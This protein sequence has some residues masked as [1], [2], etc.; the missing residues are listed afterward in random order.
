[1]S[2]L[3]KHII[4]IALLLGLIM[5]IFS[6]GQN[7]F[8]YTFDN[9]KIH[10]TPISGKYIVEFPNGLNQSTQNG[11]I[12]G[13]NAF[14]GQKISDKVYLVVDT[15]NLNNYSTNYNIFPTY[16]T[17]GDG[18]ELYI[19]SH[20]LLKFKESTTTSAKQTLIANHNLQL[21]KS[22][23]PYEMYSCVDPL[24][25]SQSIYE[26]GL[27]EYCHPDFICPNVKPNAIPN[28]EY[29]A[30]QWYLH[31][32]GQGT[33]DGK[34]TTNDADIDAPEAW[35][36][37]LGNS[38]I[39]VAVIDE[40]VTSNHPDLPN[41]R[42][43]RLNGSNFASP[44]DGTNNANDPSPVN[45]LTSGNNH[46][47][48]CA[49]VIGASHNNNIGISGIAPNCKILPVKIPFGSIPSSVYVD[50]I[51]FAYQNADIL[52]NSWGYGSSNPNLIPAI[53]TAIEDAIDD[54]KIVVFAAGNT[55]DHNANYGGFVS[56]PGNADIDNLITVGASD[57]ND[58]QANYSPTDEEFEIVAP[59][60]SAY[61]SQIAGEAFNV[62]TI[63]IPGDYGYNKWRDSWSN[64]LPNVG[65]FL[66]STGSNAYAY[67]GRFG[68]TSAACPQVA[69]V[70][71]L[72]LSENPCLSPSQIKDLLQ[73][74][75]DKVGSYNYNWNSDIPGHSKEL[76]FGRL[77]AY[78]AVKAAQDMNSSTLDLYMRDRHDDLG[79]DAGYTW[80]WDFDDSPDI[81]VR[82]QNDGLTNQTHE[83]PEYQAS[84]PVYVYVRVGNKSCVPS[85]GNEKLA[86]YWTKASS[87]SSW[88]Q[89]WDGT[90]PTVGNIINDLTI[91]V[92]QPGE[93]TIL[94]FTWN[95]AP[96]TGIGTTWNNCLLA[97]IENSTVDAITVHPNDLGQDVYQN[98]N[99]SLRNCVVTNYINGI[100]P[101]I[102]VDRERFFYIGN[103]HDLAQNYDIIFRNS[104]NE[105][106]PITDVAEVNVQLDQQGWNLLV[107][108]LSD[109]QDIRIKDNN[110]FTIV[111]NNP[112]SLSNINFPANTR[113]PVKIVYNFLTDEVEN[114]NTYEYH[115]IQK[116]TI[117]HNEL[118]DHWT[119]G[120]HFI[121]NKGARNL[122]DADAGDDEEIDKGESITITAEQI[123]EAA[124]YNWYDSEGNLIFTGTSL[125][126]SPEVTEKYKL[127]VV[128]DADGFK[129][130]DEV[131]VKV[132][133]YK[134]E[135]LSPN[136]ANTNVTIEY[137][138]EGANSAYLMIV[139]ASNFTPSNNYI[140]NSSQTETNIDVTNYQTGIYT[141][142]LVVDGQIVDAMALMIQ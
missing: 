123:N 24:S 45:S 18:E 29:F 73:K 1:M 44:Y 125:S 101:P 66:P 120:V 32:T 17:Q 21:I 70:S 112:V 72:M 58:N 99:V 127:E 61:N 82:N 26:S 57:R 71:A 115:V 16:L 85:S 65:E 50:A 119:G 28:D 69:G 52:S 56:F 35:D 95:I 36:L 23:S 42:Q 114:L 12:P 110:T 30:Q 98:N 128:A 68:G 89:N 74:S 124:K 10:L 55:A 137:D 11:M 133:R 111:G 117:T 141:V 129:D 90:D 93:S 37:S 7:N 48:S 5:P 63:D 105:Q 142:A 122:F 106:N 103:P 2:N 41:S 79:Y 78:K 130:Y 138:V 38:S 43:V 86:L 139:G 51:V 102:G 80:T 88:P 113:L 77:N 19:T 87:N 84:S 53:V 25:K 97:R 4:R 109:R 140:L 94:T 34:S 39:V 132:N 14:P 62:W 136:P 100:A 76:G 13:G 33:N 91:P 108:S 31:N 134:I 54:G 47:N 15:N 8:Y 135:I 83:N 92:L 59:S 22:T 75:T 64:P 67:T 27:V 81:W 116:N 96:N 121:I 126:V 6:F 104:E 107:N 118:G 20:I 9:N 3:N 60:H 131:E 40:G 46:G 49:G